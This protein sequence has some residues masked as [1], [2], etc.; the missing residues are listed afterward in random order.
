[1]IIVSIKSLLYDTKNCYVA[2]GKSSQSHDH[3]V[4]YFTAL[5]FLDDFKLPKR[6]G[7]I[8]LLVAHLFVSLFLSFCD[9][10]INSYLWICVCEAIHRFLV[11]YDGFLLREMLFSDRP[12]SK[13]TKALC[14]KTKH[15]VR[16]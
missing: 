8:G 7:I 10:C 6:E 5:C 2:V 4:I 11:M 9:T 3:V 16:Y 12:S 13:I 15:R 14:S 1:M